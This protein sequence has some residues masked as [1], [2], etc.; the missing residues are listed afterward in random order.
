MGLFSV[1]RVRIST[2]LTGKCLHQHGLI[3]KHYAE[4]AASQIKAYL[5][6][7]L[8]PSLGQ[9]RKERHVKETICCIQVHFLRSTLKCPQR[10]FKTV[11][12]SF[13]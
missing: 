9:R 8:R 7:F 1:C 4:T 3:I 10:L 2:T 11:L 13:V 5:C 6:F 12:L